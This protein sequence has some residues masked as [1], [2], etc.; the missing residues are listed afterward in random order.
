MAQS[1]G[2]PHACGEG[3]RDLAAGPEADNPALAALFAGDAGALAYWRAATGGLAAATPALELRLAQD[4][5]ALRDSWPAETVYRFRGPMLSRASAALR[6]LAEDQAPRAIASQA[7][8]GTAICSPR[9][10]DIFPQSRSIPWRG[11]FE[12]QALR[13]RHRQFRGEISPLVSR[14]VF[15]MTDA[16]TVLPYDPRNDQLL[17]VRQFRPGPY[18]RG[19]LD[20]AWL[21]EAVAGRIDTGETPLV[22]ARREV[23]EEA[24]LQLEELIAISPHYPSPG[25]VTEFLY[26]YIGITRLQP[27]RA[28]LHGLAEEAEDILTQTLP[29]ETAM[30][31]L[32]GGEIR[33][34]PLA[35]SL[36]ALARLRA[37]LRA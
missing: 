22:A 8:D 4:I 37:R 18:L 5:L 12:T 30:G 15:V 35:L 16:V 17:L 10:S 21:W 19:A 29:F 9:G 13:L 32:D 20:G 14:E 3:A 33:S 31:W 2:D 11:F 36:L 28:E 7:G 26:P 6:A 25:A 34:G 23:E 27:D 24:G 1:L